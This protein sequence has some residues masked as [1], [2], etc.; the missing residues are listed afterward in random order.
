MVSPPLTLCLFGAPRDTG[1]RGV[2]ALGLAAVA[3]IG[4][5]AP[6]STVTVFDNGWGRRPAA[7]GAS[8]VSVVLRG[9]RQSRRVHRPESWAN[10]HLSQ[11][12]GLR[13]N[14]VA[15][16]IRHSDAVLDVSG[17]DS[18][19]DIY[20]VKRFSSIMQPKLATLRARRPLVLLPQTYGPFTEPTTR[21]AAARVL[22]ECS[23]AYSRDAASHDVLRDLLG[24]AYDPDRHVAGVDMAFS[25]EPREPAEGLLACV[26]DLLVP[27]RRARPLVG[28]NVSGLVWGNGGEGFGLS[29]DYAATTTRLVERLVAQDVDLLLIPHVSAGRESDVDAAE[30][31]VSRLSGSASAHVWVLPDTLSAQEVKWVIARLDWFCGTRMHATI[32]GLSSQVPTAGIAY[33]MKMRGVFATCGVDSEVVDARSNDTT[34]AVDALVE[35]FDRRDHVSRLL[36]DT[37]PEVVARAQG[38]VADICAWITARTPVAAG[39]STR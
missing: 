28:V 8:G 14:P 35:A 15:R 36:R 29:I 12:L 7:S 5:G 26:A 11:R 25:L 32:A 22:R 34:S 37:A 33:S 6:G 39:G 10:V 13:A 30:Q 9:V 16:S 2:E 24:D 20:G 31:L 3:G 21:R 27:G 19:S 38:Q 17:G 18:F 23:L 4:Q 1:N